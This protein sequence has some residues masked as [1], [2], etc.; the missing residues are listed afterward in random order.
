MQRMIDE[1]FREQRFDEQDKEDALLDMVID[2][3]SEDVNSMTLE[4]RN[5]WA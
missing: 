3:I 4:N 5:F 1:M 2:K